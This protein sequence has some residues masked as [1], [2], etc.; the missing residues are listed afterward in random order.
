MVGP[1]DVSS[2][3][4][5]GDG[6]VLRW[7]V[8]CG[9]VQARH[10]T[11]L[12]RLEQT[13]QDGRMSRDLQFPVAGWRVT[14][15]PSRIK[16]AFVYRVR[17]TATQVP[18]Y[19]T[20]PTG[21]PVYL[22][23]RSSVTPGGWTGQ[24]E[25]TWLSEGL[26]PSTQITGAPVVGRTTPLP[27]GH[28]T[29][30]PVIGGTTATSGASSISGASNSWLTVASSV[31]ALTVVTIPTVDRT[32]RR[33]SSDEETPTAEQ[34][35]TSQATSKVSEG[36][37]GAQSNGG[38]TEPEAERS[39]EVERG[40]WTTRSSDKI[41]SNLVTSPAVG[42][43]VEDVSTEVDFT[44]RQATTTT[45]T[46][47]ITT[48]TSQQLLASSLLQTSHQNTSPSTP[49]RTQISDTPTTTTTTRRSRK[50]TRRPKFRPRTRSPT[51]KRTRAPD[52]DYAP[53]VHRRL[54]RIVINAG[55]VLFYHIAN[56]TFI[57]YQV[58]TLTIC[59]PYYLEMSY[60]LRI[61][62]HTRYLC[63]CSRSCFEGAYL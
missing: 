33:I 39:P 12:E 57:D 28:F 18:V 15:R 19:P 49:S 52:V 53:V 7:N 43:E 5:P 56:D 4:N 34:R 30:R 63:V 24:S 20:R 10:M 11:T 60:S 47:T 50:K 51:R 3:A 35:T 2:P 40:R 9:N 22:V 46:T 61:K 13:A 38:A 1:G 17:P 6:V 14:N 45:T 58:L 29:K 8:G 41:A 54:D 31:L 23:T 26:Q 44:T 16:R 62:S 25:P 21:S 37:S 59:A 27:P 55:D 32:M 48:I 36:D 42:N